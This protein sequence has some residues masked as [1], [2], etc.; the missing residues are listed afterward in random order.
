VCRPV[1]GAGRDVRREAARVLLAE[2]LGLELVTGTARVPVEPPAHRSEL[3]DLVGR[4]LV[5]VDP[6]TGHAVAA[7]LDGR[8][9]DVLDPSPV[10]GVCDRK[11]VHDL[12]QR[13]AEDL[14]AEA[15]WVLALL[16]SPNS[17]ERAMENH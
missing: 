3:H 2:H 8:V 16:C 7:D 17:I 4:S 10:V 1:G 13:I 15:S 11:D 6:L 9:V 14:P 12:G 5:D